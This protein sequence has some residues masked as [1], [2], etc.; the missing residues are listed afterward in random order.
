MHFG[1]PQHTINGPGGFD[2]LLYTG[3]EPLNTSQRIGAFYMAC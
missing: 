2:A 1:K 3:R